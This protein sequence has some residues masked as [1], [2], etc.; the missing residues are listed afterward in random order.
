MSLIT[1]HVVKAVPGGP[2]LHGDFVIDS[3]VTGEAEILASLTDRDKGEIAYRFGF[4]AYPPLKNAV[5]HLLSTLRYRAAGGRLRAP[6]N[7][8]VGEI[9]S[10]ISAERLSG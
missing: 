4:G 2:S 10:R 9:V 1:I 8:L 3:P 6:V 7:R 5:R